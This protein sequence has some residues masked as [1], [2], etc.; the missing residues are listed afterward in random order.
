[1]LTRSSKEPMSREAKAHGQTVPRLC[2][3][4]AVLH[5]S[6]TASVSPRVIRA[7]YPDVVRNVRNCGQDSCNEVGI[8]L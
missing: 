2:Y 5:V 1:M 6:T 8:L 3:D 7:H 4:N